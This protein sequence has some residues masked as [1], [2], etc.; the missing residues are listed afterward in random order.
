MRMQYN[1]KEYFKLI[2]NNL[3]NSINKITQFKIDKSKVNA[4]KELL[5]LL[6]L[7]YNKK[8]YLFQKIYNQYQILVI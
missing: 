1:V 4:N 3:S 8:G 2:N 6:L 5:E 7:H